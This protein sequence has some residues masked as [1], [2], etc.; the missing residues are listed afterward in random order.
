MM[1]AS[2][3]SKNLRIKLLILCFLAFALREQRHYAMK[4]KVGSSPCTPKKSISGNP[5]D[6]RR[7]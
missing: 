2:S 3:N 1:A 7:H 6:K 4:P 5:G